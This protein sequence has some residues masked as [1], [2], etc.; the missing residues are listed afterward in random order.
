MNL[1]SY[2]T[3]LTRSDRGFTSSL[4]A[5]D[6]CFVLFSF[7]VAQGTHDEVRDTRQA[8]A[9]P[10]WIADWGSGATQPN[11]QEKIWVAPSVW[12]REILVWSLWPIPMFLSV[13]S[14][15]YPYFC[16]FGLAKTHFLVSSVWSI[17][18]FWSIRSGRYFWLR[19]STFRLIYSFDTYFNPANSDRTLFALIK[20]GQSLLC[21]A[22]AYLWVGSICQSL[23]CVA[24]FNLGSLI[25]SD[26]SHGLCL[27]VWPRGCKVGFK[28]QSVLSFILKRRI[29]D[30]QIKILNT[31]NCFSQQ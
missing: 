18:L 9:R 29:T 16:L 26:M 4:F 13:R 6:L 31:N 10:T 27:S 24:D 8:L 11:S 19:I 5:L 23:S 7:F 12:P 14:G 25:P 21:L 15:Q 3:C 1:R 2:F 30:I 22:N 28:Y 17:A 20:G